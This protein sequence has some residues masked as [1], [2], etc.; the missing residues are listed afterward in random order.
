MLDPLSAND[1]RHDEV[2]DGQGLTQGSYQVLLPD[3]RLQVC[4][5]LLKNDFSFNFEVIQLI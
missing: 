4:C 1:Y 5:H 3:G 2:S